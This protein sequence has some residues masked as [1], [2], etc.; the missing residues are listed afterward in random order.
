[1]SKLKQ[2]SSATADL[3]STGKAPTKMKIAERVAAELRREI[4]TG[5]LRPGDRLHN[6]RELQE[7][8]SISRP[9]L[10]E[11]LRMLESESLIVVARGQHGGARV[12]EHDPKVLARQVGACMQMRGVTLRDVWQAR[13]NIEPG[14]ARLLA[15]TDSAEAV[16]E[17]MLNIAEA[18]KAFDDPVAYGTLTND[19]SLIL[20]RYC[21]NQTLH[22]LAT[23]MQDIV[24]KQHVDV[25]VRTYATSG[26]DRMR[27][28][29]IRCREK[30]LSL[31]EAGDGQIAEKYWRDHLEESGK[32][33]FS[34]YQAGM[35]IDV[36][37]IP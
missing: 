2:V 32:V 14:A 22:I 24:A 12:T 13:S 5:K 30:L 17:M 37:Q 9:T 18:K 26:D 28:L 6:E 29:N 21:G 3:R 16:Q 35:P 27:E 23:L 20:T 36:V 11:A 34:A 4:V 31:I 10:R 25:T 15:Q 33:V 7:Q 8:F 1:M 19:F